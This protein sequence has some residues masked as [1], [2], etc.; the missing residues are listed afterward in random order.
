MPIETITWDQVKRCFSP[1]PADS[2]KGDFGHVLSVCGSYGMAG[3]AILAAA[4]AL[5]GGAGLVTA[6]LPESIYPIVAGRLPEALGLPLPEKN[7]KLSKAAIDPLLAA[8]KKS[9]VLVLGC[10]L[11]TG[12]D[13]PA[14][15]QT[16]L[17]SAP[18][19]VVLDADGINAAAMHISV[20]N[21]PR[22]PLILTPHPGEMSR[23]LGCSA[24]AIQHHR[25]DVAHQFA[26]EHGVVLVLKGHDTLIAAP[27]GRLLQS[28]TG[29]PGMA[30]GGSGDVLAGLIGAFCA[31]GLPPFE[32]AFCG[33]FLHGAA[34]DTAAARRSQR[35]M[36]PRDLLSALPGELFKLEQ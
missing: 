25:P 33:A 10:G 17:E 18:V 20:G 2:H 5:R 9:T 8:L 29:N 6:A 24:E 11:G 16:L 3:A 7:G 1:R 4:G 34:G 27:D 15:V 21:T 22:A 13:V 36:L 31:Q 23:L 30:T 35:G 14:V 32:A 26:V 12:D 19:P 28:P